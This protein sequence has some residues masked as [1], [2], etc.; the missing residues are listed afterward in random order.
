MKN[1]NNIDIGVIGYGYWGPNIVGNFFGSNNCNVRKVADARPERLKQLN[2]VFP[3]IIGVADASD[4]I[5]DP[6]ID[7]V[8]VATP[9]FTHFSLAKK[10]LENGKHVLIEEPMTS[11]IH[12]GAIQLI[13]LAAKKGLTI[14]GRPHLPLYRC[15]GKNEK[16]N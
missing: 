13:E 7:A 11:S 16:I 15:G 12:E 8:V 5:S 10:A 3:S 2:R 14:H 6:D 4:I 1:S 9:V